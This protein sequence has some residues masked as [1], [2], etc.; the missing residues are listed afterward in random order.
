MIYVTL[1]NGKEILINE[2]LI[3]TIEETP[4]TVIK[5]TTGRKY[6]VMDK[7][8]DLYEKINSRSNRG[9]EPR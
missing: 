8:V 9:F 6:I 3:E 1:L 7:L 2:N 4:D 5:T